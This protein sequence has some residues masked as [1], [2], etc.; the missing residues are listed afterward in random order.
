MQ[1]LLIRT[2]YH[3]SADAASVRKGGGGGGGGGG[4]CLEVRT[5]G[6]HSALRSVEAVMLAIGSRSLSGRQAASSQVK[7]SAGQSVSEVSECTVSAGQSTRAAIYR[8]RVSFVTARCVQPD[9]KL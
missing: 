8:P 3:S 7:S 4:G 1:M 5:R 6:Y 9:S 2:D